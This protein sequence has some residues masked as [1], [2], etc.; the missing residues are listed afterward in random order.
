MIHT[1][2]YVSLRTKTR[3]L[4]LSETRRK[5]KLLVRSC[6]SSPLG[7]QMF[8]FL[9]ECYIVMC[10]ILWAF[11]SVLVIYLVYCTIR[12]SIDFLCIS[13][14]ARWLAANKEYFDSVKLWIKYPYIG[15]SKCIMEYVNGVLTTHILWQRKTRKRWKKNILD[16]VPWDTATA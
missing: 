8:E 1:I 11:L 7:F 6:M 9:Y 5:T 4:D 14:N 12:N 16:N 2:F 13:H 15:I 10:C 3:K